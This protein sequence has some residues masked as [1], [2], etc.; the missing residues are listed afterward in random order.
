MI[1]RLLIIKAF[2]VNKPTL[3]AYLVMLN[4]VEILSARVVAWWKSVTDE[5]L[6]KSMLLGVCRMESTSARSW[7]PGINPPEMVWVGRGRVMVRMQLFGG[8]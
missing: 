1:F 3:A 8:L 7:M 5:S 6:E 4:M 2:P